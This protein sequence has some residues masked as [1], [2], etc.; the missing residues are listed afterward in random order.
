MKVWP[1]DQVADA[2]ATQKAAVVATKDEPDWAHIWDRTPDGRFQAVADFHLPCG[3]PHGLTICLGDG[4]RRH[5]C[6]ACATDEAT[7]QEG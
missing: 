5:H 7:R 1:H 4:S 3:R 6:L 2:E